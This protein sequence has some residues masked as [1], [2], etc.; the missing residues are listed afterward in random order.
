MAETLVS[1][2]HCGEPA[3]DGSRFQLN[4]DGEARPM[5]CA[6]CLGVAEL[7]RTSGFEKF[8]RFRE[9]RARKA[10][11][12]LHK[13][14]QAW[15][16]V[17]DK[18]A[19]WGKRLG[20]GRHELLL[21]TEGIHC[22]A[23]S[24][25][26]RN[27]LSGKPGIDDVQVDPASGFA[28]VIWQPAKTR[29]SRIAMDL[30]RL[31]Y[32]PH[33][34]IAAEEERARREERR[35]SLKRLGVAGLGMMQV[36]MYA[37]GLYAGQAQGMDLAPQRFLEWVSLLVTTPVLLYSGRVF[38]EGA[39]RSLRAGRPG[40]D[41]PVAL[42][43][44]GAYVASC[45]NFFRGSGEV[46]FDSVVMFIFFLSVARHVEMS[47]R[48]RNQQ[49]GAMLAR[50]LPE[51]SEKLVDGAAVTIASSELVAGDRV[52]VRGGESFPADAVIEEGATEV[53]EALLTGESYPVAKATGDAVMAGSVN[54]G[55]AVTV[56]VAATGP[57]SSI[58]TLGRLLHRARSLRDS[59]ASLADRY[60]SLFVVGVL[61]IAGLSLGYWLFREPS[62][63]LGVTL[64]VLVVSCPCAFSLASPSA[65][66]AASR[67]LLKRGIILTRGQALDKLATIEQVIFDKTG[68]LTSG[69][70]TIEAVEL[71]PQRPEL[72]RAGVVRIAA[73]LEQYSAHPLA[74]AFRTSVGLP[75][76]D[77]PESA[78]GRGL[79][80]RI[81]G[82]EYR[83]GT[84]AYLAGFAENEPPADGRG[85]WL[86]DRQGWL[87]MF[88][89]VDPLREGA[90]ELADHLRAQGIGMAILSGDQEN[91]VAS[92]ARELGIED[93]QSGQTPEMKLEQL[94]A[95]PDHGKSTLMV[96]DGV[97]DA[98]V[99]AAAG[100]SI[101]V[102]SG[103]ELANSVADLIL[104]G[105]SLGLVAEALALARRARHIVRQNL[106]WAA[107]YNLVMIPLAVSGGLRPWMAAAG[108]SASSL[109]VVLNAGRISKQA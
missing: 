14:S 61:L 95:R 55:S 16:S 66:A 31:G 28:L 41:V 90:R 37:V 86:A 43:I 84:P 8:Y 22:A 15:A 88:R 93:W 108:M 44:T 20:D 68:T 81:D 49:S 18:P 109:L 91:A 47:L 48:H 25:L 52:R 106:V 54:L 100:V 50:L 30:L 33:L 3:P 5:C 1:C 4:F 24:W 27:G 71:N 67:A 35:A 105:R 74:L 69:L 34:P 21:Q 56:R 99:L 53:N 36:M 77:E 65:V 46:W 62:E 102:H 29:L 89:L 17:D 107:A 63:A 82:L 104:T 97:N 80:G 83:I 75:S 11:D 9:S 58:S 23:C 72:D 38:V 101:S 79:G 10:Q 40:M 2:F 87:A 92:V 60:A 64:A 51:W 78:Q 85:I 45:V 19:L 76:V 13:L 73:A 94:Q 26:I 7:I 6:G 12:D 42:A 57:E 103:T 39:V 98:P 96:G 70:P 59:S 32:K